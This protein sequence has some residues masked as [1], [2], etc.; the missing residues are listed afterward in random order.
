MSEGVA[1]DMVEGMTEGL[2]ECME[3]PKEKGEDYNNT[4]RSRTRH[5]NWMGVRVRSTH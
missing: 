4:R 1:E 2:E 3:F 5:T